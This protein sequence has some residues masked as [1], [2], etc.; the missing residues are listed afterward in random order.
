MR[1]LLTNDDSIHFEGIRVLEDIA[2]QFSDD[3]WV[4]APE[5]DQSGLSHSVTELAP[6]RVRQVSERHFAV[7]GT[8]ADCVIMGARHLLPEPPDL[9]LS[10][11]NSG[12][13]IA[14]DALYSGT[15]GGACEGALMGI[16][17][18]ALS[19]H[20]VYDENEKRITNWDIARNNAA[21]LIKIVLQ[22]PRKKG[23]Y[24]N[25]NFP[26]C[27]ESELQPPR[28]VTQSSRPYGYHVEKRLDGRKFP[29]FWIHG[30]HDRTK[31][32]KGSDA[33]AL[34]DKAPS[35]SAFNVNV[36]DYDMN[37]QLRT[38]LQAKQA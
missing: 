17:S 23:V 38:I 10:G 28:I 21:D 32:D 25:I 5:I 11:V 3:I 6:I 24:Y 14:D 34:F 19:Q 9:I 15:I 1:I 30:I 4:V 36:T 12:V 29:Y 20:Y 27:E 16:L 37:E 13:N 8:P 26:Q 22:M 35:I 18:I 2:R 33:E 7:R 31:F